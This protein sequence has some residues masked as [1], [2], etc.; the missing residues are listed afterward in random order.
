MKLTVFG[1]TGSTGEQIVRQALASGHEVTAVA[2]RPEAVSLTDPQLRV[3][4]GDVLDPVALHDG[5]VG[6]VGSGRCRSRAAGESRRR[7]H[8]PAA[9]GEKE[10]R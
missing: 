7:G 1:P 8:R 6:A 2:R 10:R 4:Y 9:P 5:I 3:V